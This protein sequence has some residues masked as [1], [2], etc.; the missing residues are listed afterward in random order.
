M[1]KVNGGASGCRA[2]VMAGQF[3][4]KPTPPLAQ[5]Q[6]NTGQRKLAKIQ[7]R[8][9]SV[10]SAVRAN[11]TPVQTQLEATNFIPVSERG[12]WS[13]RTLVYRDVKAFLNEVGGDPREAR[14]WLTQFQ[15]A[16]VCKAPA[17]AVLEV[18]R[19]MSSKP[20]HCLTS[21]LVQKHGELVF[22]LR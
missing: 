12:V 17:F 13:N 1:A 8:M 11:K 14:Y 15:R 6:Q 3:L 5:P 10:T 2:I 9:L 22:H 21:N 18:S 19:V 4:S 16:H 7:R 20:S